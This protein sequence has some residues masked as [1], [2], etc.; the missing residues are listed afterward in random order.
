MTTMTSRE[1]LDHC[2]RHLE[3]DRPGLY[4]RGV[5]PA[6]PAHASYARVRDLI[7]K[8]GDLKRWWPCDSV[9]E[10]PPVTEYVEAHSA[11]FDQHVTILHTPAGDLR[12]ARLAGR[13]GQPGML[14][15]HLLKSPGDIER[16]LS[17]PLPKI[18]DDISSYHALWNEIG[19]RGI[20]D[21]DLAMNPAGHV[22]DLLGSTAFAMFSIEHRDL[23]HALMQRRMEYLLHVL[24]AVLSMGVGPYFALLGQEYI[25]PPLHGPADFAE[26]NVRYDKP[27]AD[28]V[29]EA[30]GLL[31]VHCH[32]PLKD[33]LPCFIE[34][35]ANVVHPLEPPPMGDVTPK[36][37]KAV[38]RGKVTIEG[39][40]QIG[41]MYTKTANEI[42]DMTVGLIEDAFDDHR[43]LIVC[44]T[45]SPYVP[46]MTAQYRENVEVLVKTVTEWAG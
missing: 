13:Q 43:G 30:G 41:D 29:H 18:R 44:P 37:A 20:V 19:D 40:I 4:L 22:A 1:R 45:A 39:N 16:Y 32:G 21:A 10:P 23:L 15:E 46:E 33:V 34:I 6:S 2:Y 36:E 9:A 7:V 25:T 5:S 28:M 14:S 27:I 35:G 42:R 11:E 26:F 17:L 24:K 12:T 8:H 31:H 3:T 38:F